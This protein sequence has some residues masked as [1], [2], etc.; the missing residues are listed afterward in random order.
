MTKVLKIIGNSILILLEFLIVSIIAFAFFIRTSGFQTLLAH[1]ATNYLTEY[2]GV[3]VSI[4]KVDVAFFDKVY[5]DN[6]FIEDQ[7][8]DTLAYIQELYVNFD[9]SKSADLQFDLDNVQINQ[10]V[11]FLKKYRDEEVLNLQFIIDAFKSD[12]T[13]TTPDFLINATHFKLRNSTFSYIN[14]HKERVLYGVDYNYI[15]LKEI[16]VEAFD[17]QIK[18]DSYAANFKEVSFID[19]SGFRLTDLDGYAVFSEK[20]LNMGKAELK[21]NNS[22]IYLNSFKLRGEHIT[23]FKYF[24]DSVY[25][26]GDLDTSF[27]SLKDIAY[28]APQLKGM[29]ET[30]TIAASTSHPV[31]DMKMNNLYLKYGKGSLVK[32]DF[33]LPDF[34]IL[35][36]ADIYQHLDY[37]LVY[38]EDLEKLRLPDSSPATYIKWPETLE[39][40]NKI[41]GYN[42][43]ATGS[44]T[45]IHLKFSTL[46][47]NLGTV[48]FTNDFNFI[49]DRD[50]KE[51]KI[52][53]IANTNNQLQVEN[54]DINTILGKNKYGNINGNIGIN[55]ATINKDGI[56]VKQ[57]SGILRNTKIYDYSYDYVV[58]DRVDY[59]FI[60]HKNS[61][62]SIL[63]GNVYVRD[64]NLD[65]TFKGY[66]NVGNKMEIIGDI[67]LECA[68]L[69]EIF[70]TV[71]REAEINTTISVELKGNGLDDFVGKLS[72][73]SMYYQEPGKVLETSDFTAFVIHQKEKDSIEIES[74][75][76]NAKVYGKIDY[77]YIID[78][79]GSQIVKIFPALVIPDSRDLKKSIPSHFEYD[80]TIKKINPLLNVIYP[81][82]QIA[83]YTHI[84]GDFQEAKNKVN[85]NIHSDYIAFDSI[86][87]NKIVANH[88]VSNGELLL[89]VNANSFE[90]RDS[91]FFKEIHLTGLAYNGMLDMQLMFDNTKN[92]P[93]NIE[94]MINMQDKSVIS[95]NLF[96]SFL[97][98]GTHKW[99]IQDQTFMR[100]S[101]GCFYLGKLKMEHDNQYIYAYGN[102]SNDESDKLYVD[103]MDFQLDEFSEFMNPLTKYS[104]IANI[105]GYLTSPTK[106]IKFYGDAIIRDLAVNSTNVGDLSFSANYLSKDEKINMIGDIFS[107]GEQT[108]QFEGDYYIDKERKDGNLDFDMIFNS[109]DISIANEFMDPDV[110]KDIQGKLNGMLHLTGT[111]NEPILTGKLMLKKGMANLSLLGS[112]FYFEG[113]IESYADGIFVNQMP[114]TDEE[115]NVGSITGSLFHKGFKDMFFELLFNMEEHPYKRMPNDRSKPLPVERFLVMNNTYDVDRAYYGKAY[116]TG[117][118]TISGYLDNLSIN[119]NAK[120][121]KGTRIVLPMYGPTTIEEDGF[122][123]FKKEGGNEE[124]EKK[125]DLTGVDLNMNIDVTDQAEV[126]II[127]D[128]KTGDELTARGEGN[129]RMSVDKFNELAMEGVYTLAGGSYNFVMGPYRQ[130]FNINSGG[131]LQWTG[132]PYDAF[133]DVSAYYKTNANFSTVM[134]DV[135]DAKS[136]SNQ[137]VFAY[138]NLTGKLMEPSISFD[139]E[140]PKVTDAGSAVL[141]RIKSDR[142]ELNRQFFSLVVSKSFLPLSGT[143]GS[144]GATGSAFL[145]LASSQINAILNRMTD[146]YKM[147]VNLDNDDYSGQFSGELGISK[148]FLDDRLLISGSVG[149]GTKKSED[150]TTGETASESQFLG[151]VEIEYLL[152]QKGTFRL[153]VFNKSNN[154]YSIQNEGRGQF[155]QGVGIS[156]REDFYSLH[157]FKLFQFFAN[158]FRKKENWVKIQEEEDDR[159]PIPDKY[160]KAGKDIKE[161]GGKS[162]DVIGE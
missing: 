130:T 104:G 84:D 68:R 92:L 47:T 112:N 51:I 144:S 90:H 146:G 157:D 103:I 70:P 138:I 110:M 81:K 12:K 114:M 145:D 93:S 71:K 150:V 132:N 43:I 149:V 56:Q 143:S 61:S 129:I 109:T 80:L 106:G 40:L 29:D 6:L 69:N 16:N 102:L 49:S 17:V 41:E 94:M 98:V 24:I 2:L 4:G 78:Q 118:T 162:E 66:A 127:F 115:G 33:S 11:F 23:S 27:V 20:G 8:K 22:N 34:R 154:N 59:S 140:A 14:E 42:F 99:N 7:H 25:I 153:N 133:I 63:K 65:L 135:T 148:S 120:T 1:Y 21:T 125:V 44:S 152:N 46:V 136:S 74:K 161:E 107:I 96:P 111:P 39:K 88:E 116:V 54:L 62:Q 77:K 83:D 76:I 82:L 141:A 87:F 159:I 97:T 60:S 139:I 100:Y 52:I 58:L 64:E 95:A 72:I 67:D 35:S 36:E 57:I 121:Q 31:K 37:F 19:K 50:F 134:P 13:T 26:E 108:F 75:L 28:F 79:L 128:D 113:G 5:F 86:R 32:G 85:L 105:S 122:I 53:P 160:F 45:N 131:I 158:M 123:T 126:K 124:K 38:K 155:T 151:D 91:T 9:L 142:D 137:E 48:H 117:I 156:Y 30:V 3:K 73:D 10:A 89:L 18:K 55:S 101:E 15:E 147:N 119:V